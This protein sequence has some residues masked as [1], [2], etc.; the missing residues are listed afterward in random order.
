MDQQS[1]ERIRAALEEDRDALGRQLTDLGAPP[2]SGGVEVDIE[3]GFA[4]SAQA[5]AERSQLVSLL[6]ELQNRYRE[7][8][9]AL[10]RITAGTYG[11]CESCGQDISVERLEALPSARLCMNCKQAAGS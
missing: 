6:E 8:V 3:E 1:I 7:V 2:E 9:G 10:D 11:K 4:D 5:T